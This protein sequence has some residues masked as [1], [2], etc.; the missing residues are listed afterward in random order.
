MGATYAPND[1]WTYRFGVALD[2]TPIPS[3]EHHT[4]RIP[5]E[6]RTWLSFGVGYKKSDTLSFE[7][8]YAHLWVDDPVINKTATGEDLFRGNLTGSYDASVDILSAQL[9]YEF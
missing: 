7:F 4:P 6:D 1:R 2:K 9:N 5:G 3:A 8:G